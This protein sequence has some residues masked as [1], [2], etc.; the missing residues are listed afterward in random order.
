MKKS[1]LLLLLVSSFSPKIW[2]S[3][4][5]SQ[6]DESCRFIYRNAYLEL[7]NDVDGFNKKIL[8]NYEMSSRLASLYLEITSSQKNCDHMN[9]DVDAK[10]TV[11]YQG[12]YSSLRN[13]LN[14]GLIIS[15]KQTNVD[16]GPLGSDKTKEKIHLGII[17][18]KCKQ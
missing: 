13:K 3:E 17:D 9:A 11:E 1:L 7:S 16:R 15:G 6:F 12:L 2:A 8:S 4:Y 5:P 10:C 14:I 18:L